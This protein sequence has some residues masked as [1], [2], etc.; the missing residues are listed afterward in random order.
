[1]GRM[2]EAKFIQEWGY[3]IRHPSPLYYEHGNIYLHMASTYV[4][5]KVVHMIQKF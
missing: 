5:V 3:S 4:G 1:M 2:P